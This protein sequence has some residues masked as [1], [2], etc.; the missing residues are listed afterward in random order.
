MAPSKVIDRSA[1]P[2]AP[3]AARGPDVDMNKV[4]TNPPFTAFLGN[5]SYDA[6]EE[7]IEKFFRGLTVSKAWSGV[8]NW[9]TG[10]QKLNNIQ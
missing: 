2:T 1:L 4:P 9:F 3:R 8:L 7:E 6:N 10:Y 5:L